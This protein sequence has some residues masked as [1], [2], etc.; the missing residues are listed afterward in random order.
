[1]RKIVTYAALLAL[2]ACAEVP[3]DPVAL[4]EYKEANDPAEPTNRA[5]FAANYF[6]DRNL[7][8]PVARAYTD[9]MPEAAKRSIHNFGENLGAPEVLVND[10]LQGNF[11][12]AWTT[13]RRFVVNST[14]GGAGFFDL[15]SDWGLPHHSADFGQTFGVW[16][17]G[18]GPSLQLPLLA[19]SNMRDASGSLLSFVANPLG[20]IPGA[21]I[22]DIRLASGALGLADS[23]ARLLPVTD[24]LE[25]TSVDYYAALRSVTASRRAALVRQGL[26]D[27]PS[28]SGDK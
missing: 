7:L 28:A 11:A 20:Y 13:T 19:F 26:S 14:V 16:G 22:S 4:A 12:K 10:A 6:V 3:T 24:N 15:A 9:Y 27:D 5:I 1:M 25:S 18:T 2:A 8:Q 23:R 21:T 17:M